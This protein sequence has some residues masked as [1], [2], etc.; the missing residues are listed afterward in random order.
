MIYGNLGN[1]GL[2]SS[3]LIFGTMTFNLGAEWM[4]GIASVG[5]AAATDMV[6]ACLDAG[7]NHF[8]TAD[9][10]SQG[11]SEIALGKALGRRRDDAIITT[12]YGFRNGDPITRSGLSR[13][14]TI[15]SVEASLNR[16]GTDCIDVLIIHKEDFT[17]PLEETLH[18]LDDLIRAGKLRYVGVSNWPAW[19]VA[20][21]VQYQQD[22][23][24]S[25]FIAGQML[26]NLVVRDVEDDMLPMMREMG[27]GLMAWS[28]LAGGLLT[29]KYDP[30]NL[31]ASEGRLQGGDF[32]GT[33]VDA[34]K[35]AIE[36]LRDI[37]AAHK[38]EPAQ[39]ALAWAL[40]QGPSVFPII[41]ASRMPHLTSAITAASL[42]LTSKDMDQLD[43]IAPPA[44]RYPTWFTDFT[45]DEVHKKHLT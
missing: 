30:A 24:M 27:L 1:S 42:A 40:A 3:R 9:G 16:L 26:Y 19:R 33:P 17:T 12:K 44:R 4:P 25:Q 31:S 6:A 43:A 10:Y 22:N 36:T 7:I 14:H 35:A 21:A 18:T 20:R 34:A 5:Q 38:S 8:D 15:R 41:G 13:R 29:G 39:I 45:A 37:A 11:E 23:H 32:L 2:I 28:P